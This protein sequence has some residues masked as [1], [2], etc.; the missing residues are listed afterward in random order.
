MTH[1][2]D[3]VHLDGAPAA[4]EDAP[5][6]RV[7]GLTKRFQRA[8]GSI[9]NAIDG[10]DLDV[11]PGDFIVLL[12]PSGCGKTT[13]L[14]SIA[15]LE[16]PDGGEIKIHGR[17]NFSGASGIEV[18]PERRELSMIFQSY[19]LWPHMTAFQNVA[20]PLESK[21]GGK[22][23]KDEI[24]RR[25]RRVL[26]LVG[27]PELE[28]QYP[29]QMSGGQ[30]QR[31]ALARALVNGDGLVLFDEPLSNVDAKVREQL[32]VELVTM[33]RELGFSAV[34]VTHDQVE[35]M[36]LAHRIA[37]LR[38]GRVE[39]FAPPREVYERPS[40]RYVANFIGTT[41]ELVGTLR[42]RS[43][44]EVVVETA[45]GAVVGVPSPTSLDA[46]TEV[47]ALWRPERCRLTLEEPDTVNR[48]RARV[49]ASM[50]VGS[51]TEYL[52]QVGDRRFRTWSADSDSWQ[53]DTDVWL[54]VA[55]QHV[56]VLDA[57]TPAA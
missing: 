40:T 32:R 5:V 47:A 39:Q 43:A 10:V 38:N 54:S 23:G 20:Y 1:D 17:M 21:R 30:Q 52:V 42:E 8:D 49:Q 44:D 22:V 29:N 37:V 14:R 2:T 26:E 9:V 28:R 51:H 18:P 48:W 45:L 55:P 16:R 19:A 7:R 12:G 25:V 53:S 6:V 3:D 11:A 34:F 15:G 31:V 4:G 33:Q 27:I 35:A 41:N 24:A 36:E 50:F 13:L 46:G 57:G 56:R